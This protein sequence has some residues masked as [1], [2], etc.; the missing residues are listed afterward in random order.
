MLQV[1]LVF[2]PKVGGPLGLTVEAGVQTS[3]VR[4]LPGRDL[5]LEARG[6]RLEMVG[7]DGGLK[8]EGGFTGG[9]EG[10]EISSNADMSLASSTGSV[11]SILVS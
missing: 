7:G 9:S 5:T 2:P 4:A 10:V 8:I 3:S 11:S 6:G 1:N